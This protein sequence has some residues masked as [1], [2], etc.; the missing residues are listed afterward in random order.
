[1][2]TRWDP[3]AEIARLQDQ[4]SRYLGGRESESFRGGFAPS[5]D[6]YEDD[7][8]VVVKAELA[9]IKPEDVH[10]EVQNDVLTLRGERK[11]EREDTRE[12]KRE[13][14]HRIE[15]AYGSFTRS[16]MLPKTVDGDRVE[17]EMSDG[18]LSIRIPKRA[19]P[20]PRRIDVKNT[21]G[22]PKGVKTDKPS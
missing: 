14:Y 11:L 4:F 19:A 21:G 13:R 6:I 12:D 1:M 20:E 9:G 16:F 22:Q 2:L 18:V 15:R 17:A 8:S 7:E 3:F 10:I 5:V